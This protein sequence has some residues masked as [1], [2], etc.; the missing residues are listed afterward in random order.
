M[1]KYTDYP[2]EILDIT[3][4]SLNHEGLGYARYIHPPTIGSN[5]KHLKLLIK[6]VVPGDKVRVSVPNAKGRKKAVLQYDE[7]LEPSPDRDLSIPVAREI[8]GGAPLQYMLYPKQLEFKEQFVKQ[9]LE[10]QGIDSSVVLPIIGM[11][12]PTRYRNKMELSFGKDG[13]IGMHEQGN[14]MKVID[15]E[16]SILAPEIM[17]QVKHI[18]GQWQKDWDLPG[19]DKAN[20]RGLLRNLMMRYSFACDELMVVIYA[21]E[22]VEKHREAAE[23]L[24]QRLVDAF[25]HLKSLQWIKYASLNERIAA[26][27]TEVLYGRDYIYDQLNGNQFRIWP[28]TFFQVNPTQA[29]VLVNTALEMA[30]VSPDDQVIDLFCGI[31]TFSLPFAQ[32]A[33]S[34]TGI[35]L[36]ENSIRSARRNATDNQIENTQFIA[37]DARKGLLQVQE[38]SGTPDLLI[39]DPPRSG[40]GGK[41]MRAIGRL[42]PEKIVYVSCSPKSLALD[43]VWLKDYGYQLQQIQPVDQFSSTV[44]VECVV[45]MSRVDK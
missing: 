22:A 37:S 38:T 15:L 34:L 44:H 33:K 11:D 21:T 35:E 5:G 29:E 9:T 40:A 39:L 42:A 19:Y 30:E 31:G 13:A 17:I 36:V 16:D 4:E 45:L 32:Q 6:N 27:E 23:D 20:A 2:T 14:P 26:E 41:M 43:L 12:E 10:E 3:I 18:V 28:D 24:T 8:S 1:R 7:L 25:D